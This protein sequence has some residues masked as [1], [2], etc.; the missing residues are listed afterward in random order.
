MRLGTRGSKLALAQANSCA[1]RMEE[2]G[3]PVQIVVIKT[4]GDLKSEISLSQAG[5]QGLFTKELE[6]A[7]KRGEIDAAVHSLKDLPTR[8]ATGLE[9]GAVS[10]REDWR[11][12]W[13]SPSPFKELP[14]GAIIGTGSPRRRA[15]LLGLRPD[16]NFVDFRGNVD[17]R[18]RKLENGE[19]QGAV[20]AAAGLSRLGMLSSAR[21]L[22]SA[23]EMLP[24]PGQGF[25]ALEMRQGDLDASRALATMHDP[26]AADC[27]AAERAFLDRLGAGCHAPVG[28]LA[29]RRGAQLELR[30]FTQ[31]R[32]GRAFKG[33]LSGSPGAGDD[34]GRRLAEELLSQG[35]ELTREA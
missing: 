22:F 19:V 10:T 4:S 26:E 2:A 9:L 7:L 27:A 8:I 34:L 17:T 13:L 20:L 11:D 3:S 32:D 21:S 31:N 35:A 24:A 14:R 5:G 12:A 33:E 18:L 29:R 25:L 23:E 30:G 1:R 15:Q 28:A 6:E 16:L